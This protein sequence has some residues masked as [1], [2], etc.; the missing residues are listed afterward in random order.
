[1]TL[2]HLLAPHVLRAGYRGGTF[3]PE[4]LFTEILA[5][6]RAYDDPAVWIAR[7]PEAD[8]LARARALPRDAASIDRLPLY[9]LPFAVKD[10]ID[11]AGMPTTAGCPAFAFVP[12]ET[13]FAVRR[14]L[15]AGAILI[16]KTNLDQFATGLVGTRSPHGAPRSVFNRNYIS[17]GSSSGSAVAVAAGLCAFS[18]GTDTAG[19]GRVPASFN[20]IVGLKP[21]RGTI[22]TSGVLPACR[23]LDCVSIFAPTADDARA[24]ARV[25]EAFDASDPYSRAAR[26][27]PLP[28]E[29]VRCGVLAEA[30]RE[31]CGD[32]EAAALYVGAIE[33]MRALGSEIVELDYAPFR[34]TAQLL[35]GGPWVAERLAAIAPFFAAH[36]DAIEPTVRA[37]VGAAT[38]YS[39]VDAYE[40]QYRLRALERDAA[41]AWSHFDVMLLPTAPTTYTVAD[42]AAD[43]IATNSR[44]GTYTNFVNLLDYC[45]IAVP[46]GFRSNGLPFGISF[47]GPTF[48][49][50]DLARIATRFEDARAPS[51]A[52]LR[53]GEIAVAVAGAH[54]SGFPLNH[55]L[56][57]RGATL[58]GTFRTDP[59]YRL[60][61]LAN[62]TPPKPGLVRDPE[63]AGAGIEVEVWS[64]APAAFGTFVA[65]LPQPMG[66]GRVTLADGREVAGFLC[67][68]YAL[69]GSL[70][71]T[72]HGGWRAY[73]EAHAP[74]AIPAV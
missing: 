5:R 33:R 48:S 73:S 67:E 51:R 16:G 9:G 10:N 11:V 42:V 44:L 68:R 69:E 63:F 30:D 40:A 35:Y 45:A 13:A 34:E 55:Q 37:I 59:H 72:A 52:P 53:R 26:D 65:G 12:T 6:V 47:V 18:L 7:V 36:A 19:S 24:V 38:R 39:A 46:A 56:L 71:I 20:N 4:D 27:T 29:A 1:M 60:F 32:G 23:S 31:F 15:A 66:I 8:V 62:T 22:S 61:A 28:T 2:P 74:P 49:D 58:L 43:P 50:D 14:L 25:A 57:E 21:T 54:L 64:L 70:E 3:S 17:G 41:R